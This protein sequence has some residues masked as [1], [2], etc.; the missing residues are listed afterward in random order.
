EVDLC[1]HATLATAH[2]LFR[3]LCPALDRLNFDTRSG[4]LAVTREGELLSMDFPSRP[5]TEAEITEALVSALGRRP[6]AVYRARDLMAVFDSP[7]DIQALQPDFSRIA[8]LDTFALIVTA[9]G[10]GVDFVSR[11]FA[12]A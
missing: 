3:Y 2:V 5:G 4:N 12:P 7:A 8:A 10:A 1:G 6:R 11:F 9:P